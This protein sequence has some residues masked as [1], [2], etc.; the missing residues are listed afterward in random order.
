MVGRLERV[1]TVSPARLVLLAAAFFYAYAIHFAHVHYL[2]PVW[3]Y[4][5][6]SYRDPSAVDLAAIALLVVVGALLLPT[7]IGKA[8]SIV[9]LLLFVVVYVPTIVL[10]LALDAPRLE[11]YGAG[12]LA[13]GLGFGCACVAARSSS[14]APR[15]ST[16]RLPGKAFTLFVLAAWI[17]CCVVLIVNQ[18]SVMAF[19]FES[20]VYE[21]RAAGTATSLGLGYVQTYFANVLSP[22][23]IALGAVKRR[24]SL[25]ALG[26]IGCVLMYMIAAQRT[27]LLLPIAM[28]AVL[29][30]LRVRSG[31]F[32][33]SS[34]LLVFLGVAEM[35]SVTFYQDNIVASVLSLFLVNRTLGLPGLTFHQYYDVFG[36]SGFTWWSHVRGVDFFVAA[37]PSYWNDTLWPNL[38]HMIGDRVYQNYENNANANLF[39]GDGVAAAGALGV[40]V[41]GIVFAVWLAVMDRVA[42]GWDRTFV[43][44]VMV[45][46]ALSLTNVHLFTTLLSLG[47]LFW[48][49]MLYVFR[50]GARR[51]PSDSSNRPLARGAQDQT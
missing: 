18:G 45:P 37:P 13:L 11:L 42:R 49:V 33:T 43:V 1:I 12:L 15:E 10:T 16:Q 44:L 7:R 3:G 30:A 25:V 22:G 28:L 4:Y 50:L 9:V 39:V 35:V 6:Y 2:T 20:E 31:V 14:L 29:I 46:V 40:L 8:S 47:G 27:V 34:F 26:T 38:G 41:I 21:Q 51:T 5:G 19:A 32:R 23:L 48:M 17:V 24:W 36:V